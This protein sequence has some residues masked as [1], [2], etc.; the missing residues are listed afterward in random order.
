MFTSQRTREKDWDKDAVE[1][2]AAQGTREWTQALDITVPH[3]RLFFKRIYRPPTPRGVLYKYRPSSK[4]R[5]ST[6]RIPKRL[7]NKRAPL[8]KT[9][10]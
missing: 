2:G 1:Q 6:A 5:K 3:L 8:H 7:R 9:I 10:A 4:D